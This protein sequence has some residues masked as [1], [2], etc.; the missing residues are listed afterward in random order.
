M[1]Q[2]WICHLHLIGGELCDKLAV[3]IRYPDPYQVTGHRSVGWQRSHDFK[4]RTGA[5]HALGSGGGYKCQHPHQV[6]L[7]IEGID[8]RL[9]GIFQGG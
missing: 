4:H 5:L 6:A 1:L 9:R 2:A 7:G 8:Q 3:L